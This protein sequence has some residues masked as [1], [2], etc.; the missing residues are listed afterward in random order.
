MKGV[1]ANCGS[2]KFDLADKIGALDKLCRMLGLFSR[3][4]ATLTNVTVNQ[5][6]VGANRTRLRLR[7]VL[8]RPCRRPVSCVATFRKFAEGRAAG[9]RRQAGRI[10]VNHGG[11]RASTG[12][13]LSDQG[14]GRDEV[15]I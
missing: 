1:T 14:N 8:R 7:G 13:K 9:Y 10:G 4:C 11:P 2:L 6:N 15:A 12:G 5:V 3:R